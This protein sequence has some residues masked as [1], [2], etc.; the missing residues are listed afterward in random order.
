LA[1]DARLEGA[2]EA[3]AGLEIVRPVIVGTMELPQGPAELQIK[4]VEIAATQ[5]MNL[6]K[7][8]LRRVD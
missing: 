1:G 8:W 6:H 7:V 4:P 5:L 2:V 3:T